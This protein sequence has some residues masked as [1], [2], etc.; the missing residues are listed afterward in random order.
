VTPP[1]LV[2]LGTAECHLCHEMRDALVP[3]LRARGLGLVERDVRDDPEMERRYL[4]EI[5]VLLFGDVEV[6]RHRVEAEAL[7]ERLRELGLCP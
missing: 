4:L 2:L 1:V 7:A 3:L 6:A 5:P